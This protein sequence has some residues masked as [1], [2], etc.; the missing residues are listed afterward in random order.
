MVKILLINASPKKTGTTALFLKVFEKAAKQED[1]NTKRIDLIDNKVETFNGKLNQKIRKFH[2]YLKLILEYDGFVI[3]T[4]TYWFSLPGVLKNFIDNLTPFE[5][6]NW[7]L[8]GK[9]AGCIVYSPEGG[10]T[11]VLKNLALTFNHMGIAIP[12]Y[13]L[14]FYRDQKDKWALRDIAL[15]AKTMKFEV[16]SQRGF[17]T[18]KIYEI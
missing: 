13:G 17:M 4:P 5:E 8:E 15:L 18:S 6:N 7:M 2:P 12:P 11:E 14:I 16:E 1:I 9:V 3:A 10:G